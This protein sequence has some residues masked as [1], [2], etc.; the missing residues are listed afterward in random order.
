VF[1]IL[2]VCTGNT[3]RSTMA[4]ALAQGIIK[5]KDLT[6]K[7]KVVSAGTSAIP[8]SK[9]AECAIRVME[10]RGLS[11]NKHVAQQLTPD[12]IEEADL[13]LTM[14]RR[15]KQYVLSMAPHAQ[16]KV[17]TLKEYVRNLDQDN[18]M[19]EKLIELASALEK[20]ESDFYETTRDEIEKLKQEQSYLKK[21]LHEVERK[22]QDWHI[23]YH[24]ATKIQ[25]EALKKAEEQLLDIDILDPIGQP[26]EYYKD[27]ADEIEDAVQLVFKKILQDLPK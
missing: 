27:C 9:A 15:H 18:Y 3:C 4:Q 11:L 22:I 1:T 16:E 17:F 24:E 19:E 2:F 20:V 8:D 10:D 25:R 14:T 26:V 5:E 13:V 7:I 12:L 21:R 23:R 6:K